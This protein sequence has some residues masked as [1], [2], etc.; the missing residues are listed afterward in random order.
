MTGAGVY[1]PMSDTQNPVK[2][3]GAGIANTLGRAE[4]AAVAA[5]QSHPVTREAQASCTRRCPEDDFKPCPRSYA[6]IAGN[7]P[8]EETAKYQASLIGNNQTNTGI[9]GAT[10]AQYCLAGSKRGKPSTYG[11]T[12]NVIPTECI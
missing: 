5:A 12:S 6:E 4:L 1:H 2:P 9:P 10:F 8:A 3:N 11:S 7:E